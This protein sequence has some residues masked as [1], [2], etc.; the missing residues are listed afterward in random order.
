MKN[1][2]QNL[3]HLTL[4]LTRLARAYK[5][6]ADKLA[7]DFGLSQAS[8]WP[9]LTIARMGGGVRPGTLAERLAIEPPSLVRIIDQLLDAGLLERRD[10]AND[11]RAKLLY[12]TAEGKQRAQQLEKALIPFRRKLFNQIDE[13]DLDACMRVFDAL[14]TAILA[15]E[16]STTKR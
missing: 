9:V 14:N 3:M 10:D 7:A 13:T 5:S 2:D 6:A 4:S 8:A 11:R 1:R 12:L 16:E 15:F